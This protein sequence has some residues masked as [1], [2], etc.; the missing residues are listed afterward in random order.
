MNNRIPVSVVI[1]TKNEEKDLPGCLE[2]AFRLSDDVIVLDSG[3]SDQTLAI[4]KQYEASVYEHAFTGFGD[5]RNWAIEQIPHRYDWVLHLDADERLTESFISEIGLLLSKQPLEAGYYVPSKLMLGERWLRRSSGYPVYQVRLFHRARM[6]FT[7]YGHGQREATTGTVGTMREP[8][9]HYAFS[10]GLEA[11]FE[12]HACYAA[13]EAIQ[14]TSEPHGLPKLLWQCLVNDTVSRRRALK[15]LSF[16]LPCRGFLRLV[17]VLFLK[18]GLL[19]GKAGIA[20]ARMMATYE[21]MIS[22]YISAQKAGAS[23]RQGQIR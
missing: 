8:Y 11:W 10:K 23:I 1:L 3:S 2:S 6:R 9:L 14:A 18:R 7:N 4:A 15:R 21:S 16:R 19:D 22:T 13:A 5:Q 12:K 20:F 17:H